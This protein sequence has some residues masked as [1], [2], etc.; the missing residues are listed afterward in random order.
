[1][2]QSRKDNKGRV[3][4]R[5][6]SQRSQDM[7]Y[8]YSYTDPFGRRKYVYATDLVELRRKEEKLKRD[9]L[10]GLDIYIAGRATINF[11]FDRYIST[12]YD[13]RK[14]TRANYEY[15]YDHF[16]RK[17]FGKKLICEIK[18]SDIRYFYYYLM[19]ELH[20]KPATVDN[21][22]SV[23]H[24]TFQLAVRDNIIRSNPTD[25]VMAE[26][27]KKEGH[28]KTVRHALT[29][30]QQRAFLGYLKENP[31]YTHWLPIFTVFFGTGC[32]VGE[33]TGLRWQDLDFEN[34]S[35]NINHGLVTYTETVNGTRKSKLGIS[36]PK[37]EAGIRII[38]ML[39]EV[40]NAF[41]EVYAE[42]RKTGFNTTVIDGMD[43]FVF[44]NGHGNV[45]HP[46]NIN[47]A[48]K[49]IVSDYNA[50]EIIRAKREHRE[51]V[52][53]PMFSCH[54]ARH[55]FCTRFCE[56]ETN[57]KVIQAVM[58]H[59]DISTTLDIYAEVTEERKREAIDKL[60]ENMDIF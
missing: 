21:V 29:R 55:T 59:K 26:I 35:I 18:Y 15:I 4:L 8:I 1:M 32:R 60:S 31:M 42:Q 23:L 58:G 28:N 3:L 24:P 20:V 11:V 6:E 47:K 39:D 44:K 52:L 38:P 40:Y 49:R 33:I 16:V 51:P 30:E 43:G 13:L 48:I 54:Y 56:T 37:T 34:R 14:T 9:Q 12:K 45:M 17:E 41:R 5:G 57:V 25:G 2:A 36:Y 27:K 50:Y 19:N 22:H 53:L 10:D 46:T 7:R